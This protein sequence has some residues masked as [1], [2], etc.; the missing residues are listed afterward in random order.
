MVMAYTEVKVK[1]KRVDRK[2]MQE[3][4]VVVHYITAADE[5]LAP[6]ELKALQACPGDSDVIA[7]FQSSVREI[8]NEKDCGKPFFKATL[9]Q[10]F[11]TDSG[12]EKET[13]YRVLVH[14][15]DIREANDILQGYVKQGLDDMRIDAINKTRMEWLD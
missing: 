3:K 15:D 7:V 13:K 5:V 14:A 11:T 9:M 10:V 8:V 6:S 12:A 2:T 4:D 1:T